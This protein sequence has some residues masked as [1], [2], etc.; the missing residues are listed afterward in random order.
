MTTVAK[1]SIFVIS[2]NSMSISPTLELGLE[3][4]IVARHSGPV[5]IITPK[6]VPDATT[7]LDHTVFSI[8]SDSSLPSASWDVNLPMK[9]WMSF[10]G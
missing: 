8:E 4:F 9:L 7:V 5:Y 2:F 3:L 6:A 10:W 1:N